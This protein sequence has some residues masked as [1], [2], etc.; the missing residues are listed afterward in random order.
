ML[1]WMAAPAL[2]T[3]AH[4]TTGCSTACERQQQCTH[5][6]CTL[7]IAGCSAACQRQQHCTHHRCG[8]ATIHTSLMHAW[9]QCTP[10]S[11]MHGNKAHI[12]HA[13]MHGKNA[14][15]TPTCMATR[16]TSLMHAWQQCTP[17]HWMQHNPCVAA[18]HFLM[19]SWATEPSCTR[20]SMRAAAQ[21]YRRGLRTA[22]KQSCI[23][24]ATRVAAQLYSRGLRPVTNR[25]NID[26]AGM[27]M[28]V[29]RAAGAPNGQWYTVSSLPAP[30]IKWHS[31]P[32]RSNT[33]QPPI[34]INQT[35]SEMSS[36]ALHG[37]EATHVTQR[38]HIAPN[39]TTSTHPLARAHACSWAPAHPWA[40]SCPTGS[41]N[42]VLEGACLC[43]P[44][45][46]LMRTCT[47]LG[48]ALPNR[49][50]SRVAAKLNG[51]AI[52]GPKVVGAARVAARE[53]TR[54]AP[55]AIQWDGRKGD[56][57]LALPTCVQN[58]AGFGAHW[59]GVLVCIH[60]CGHEVGTPCNSMVWTEGGYRLGLPTSIQN[61][62]SYGVLFGVHS[63]TVRIRSERERGRGEPML[64]EKCSLLHSA[65]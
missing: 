39:P 47:P 6:S 29:G 65:E 41:P 19:G 13:C 40:R 55:H 43:L 21:Q 34:V 18:A 24:R 32:R 3:S 20:R 23:R 62:T 54:M 25:I 58:S 61:G 33:C 53:V 60:Y 49:K 48:M 59:G 52:W 31:K 35:Y 37:I 44:S 8:K 7:G 46:M 5:H 28:Q 27:N 63:M 2:A 64:M 17:H 26:T 50:P 57:G 42:L 14:H 30:L 9:Q 12:T 4:I 36:H 38:N 16:H 1:P 56:A 51:R 22:P 45:H 10:H 11:C 15:L